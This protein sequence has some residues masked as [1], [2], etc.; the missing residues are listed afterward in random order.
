MNFP[1][2]IRFATRPVVHPE[3]LVVG[4]LVAGDVVP[5]EDDIG[6]VPFLSG[7]CSSVSVAP[8]VIDLGGDPLR[9]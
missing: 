7:T 6:D 4:R 2:A 1:F 3:I 8:Q 9:S 5:A